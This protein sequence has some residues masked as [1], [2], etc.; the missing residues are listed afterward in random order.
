MPKT[1]LR[2]AD[3]VNLPCWFWFMLLRP[4]LAAALLLPQEEVEREELYP[5][6]VEPHRLKSLQ[7]GGTSMAVAAAAPAV[8]KAASQ[9]RQK[10]Q[11]E[12]QFMEQQK[13]A[14]SSIRSSSDSNS[15]G[16]N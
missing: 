6:L 5:N 8:P 12:Q 13:Q 3:C 16:S 2:R 4:A 11:Q 9:Q 15:D 1:L 14:H 7:V 10:W